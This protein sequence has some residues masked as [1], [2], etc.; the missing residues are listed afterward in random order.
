MA[1][2]ALTRDNF[3]AVGIQAALIAKEFLMSFRK[4]IAISGLCCAIAYSGAYAADAAGNAGTVLLRVRAIGVLPDERSTVSAIGGHVDASNTVVP[5]LD[6]TYFFTDAFA[7][8][9]IAAVT[10]HTASDL[11]SSA[12][13][14]P[15]GSTW[16]LPPT[17][18]AQYHI[19]TGTKLEPYVGA[20]VNFT[21]MFSVKK[22]ASGPVSAIH[23]GDS[24]GPALQAGADYRLSD[25]WS[26]N[27]DVKKVWIKSDVAINNGAIN[28]KVHLDPWIIGTGIGYRFN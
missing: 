2:G 13:T 24:F 28:A 26:L 17:L 6:F 7:V 16:L 8:E 1:R 3:Y 21:T 9:L 12:G 22:P 4:V 11:G 27:F 18:T 14:V 5:E 19:A 10:K 15:L 25:R 20:G 23:Y